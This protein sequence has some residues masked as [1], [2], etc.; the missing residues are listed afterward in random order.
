MVD[1]RWLE[2]QKNLTILN[3]SFYNLAPE[4]RSRGVNSVRECLGHMQTALKQQLCS[5]G[6]RTV[7]ALAENMIQ[8]NMVY[9]LAKEKE[10]S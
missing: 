9:G 4:D 3:T 8:V 7:A 10:C 5:D 1:S 6:M 2:F